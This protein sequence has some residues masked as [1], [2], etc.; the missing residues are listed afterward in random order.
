MI[1]TESPLAHEEYFEKKSKIKSAWTPN[2]QQRPRRA[3]VLMISIFSSPLRLP[4]WCVESKYQK[5]K[6]FLGR[7]VI[8]TNSGYPSSPV[9]DLKW[10]TFFL[11]GRSLKNVSYFWARRVQWYIKWYN[12]LILAFNHLRGRG[13]GCFLYSLGGGPYI[14]I[15][16]NR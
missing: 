2:I 11:G 15:K 6:M 12:M 14:V 9:T 8:K 1:H 13:R 10:L 4:D 3:R 16:Q 5:E 7:P